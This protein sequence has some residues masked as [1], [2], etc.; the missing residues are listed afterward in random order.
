M[1]NLIIALPH[2]TKVY[3][4]EKNTAWRHYPDAADSP[5]P[6]TCQ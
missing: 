1:F 4:D 6:N 2:L 3:D 5:S